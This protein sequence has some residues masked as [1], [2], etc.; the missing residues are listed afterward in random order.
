MFDGKAFSDFLRECRESHGLSRSEVARRANVARV[1]LI[2]WE[3]GLTRPTVD[4][5]P[6]VIRAYE[7]TALERC[8]LG[9]ILGLGPAPQDDQVAA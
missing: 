9:V 6:D 7:L 8:A 3:R 2:H 5:L 1:S 4:K